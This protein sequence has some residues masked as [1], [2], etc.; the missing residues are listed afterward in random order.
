M[1]SFFSPKS[2]LI[3]RTKHRKL[4]GHTEAKSRKKIKMHVEL[5]NMIPSVLWSL[6]NLIPVGYFCYSF[7]PQNLLYIFIGIS[8]VPCFLPSSLSD[9]IQ[10][11]NENFLRKAGVPF[12]QKW[13]QHGEMINR[14]I[15]KKYP[16]YKVVYDRR[17]MDSQY[18]KTYQFEKFHYLALFFFSLISVYALMKTYY[19][20]FFILTVTNVIYNF[21]P[22]LLQH[23]TRLRIK[24]LLKSKIS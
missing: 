24:R 17:T 4:Q 6:L 18:K 12:V 22:I 23:Y 16:K 13:A 14:L 15:R 8:I 7:I 2:S 10:I 20:W 3:Y 1:A 9:R 11:K 21:Y 19:L 5:Y